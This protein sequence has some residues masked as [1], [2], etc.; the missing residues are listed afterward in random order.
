MPTDGCI[1]GVGETILEKPS[2]VLI[3][4]FLCDLRNKL[5]D[6]L[7]I[8]GTTLFNWSLIRKSEGPYI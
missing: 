8:K 3:G 6:L 5:F 4:Q 2:K 1:E 7:R